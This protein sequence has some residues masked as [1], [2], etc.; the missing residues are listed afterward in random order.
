M[1]MC[2]HDGPGHD[3]NH[4]RT[5]CFITVSFEPHL[6]N[7]LPNCE[8]GY[9]SPAAGSGARGKK[10]NRLLYFSLYRRFD[11]RVLYLRGHSLLC[12]FLGFQ[13]SHAK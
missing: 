13:D 2:K 12:S 8:S 7:H 9:P 11:L 10:E 3:R 6:G 5:A 4:D 1:H